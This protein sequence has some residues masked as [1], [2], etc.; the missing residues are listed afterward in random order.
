MMCDRR[1]RQAV[2]PAIGRL[3]SIGSRHFF[4]QQIKA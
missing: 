4:W 2:Q 1:L 3:L